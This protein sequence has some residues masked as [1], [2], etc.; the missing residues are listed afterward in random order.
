MKPFGKLILASQQQDR[1]T[2]ID[3]SQL[4]NDIKIHKLILFRGFQAPSRDEFLQFCEKFPAM[5]TLNWSF[6]PVMEMKESDDPQNY[7]FSREKV[8]FHW[9]GAFHTVPD[10]LVFSCVN[11][12]S[13]HAGGET[14][15]TNT[16]MIF[17]ETSSDQKKIWR[18]AE[19]SY[20]TEKLA[21]YGGRIQGPLVQFHPY[22]KQNILRFAEPV[23]TRLNPV[24][25]S[26]HGVDEQNAVELEQAL[27][28]KIYDPR[29][30][31]RH[32]WQVGDLLIADNHSLIH[33]RTE[34][35]KNEPRHLRRI[36]LLRT[37]LDS[38]KS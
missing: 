8:P 3:F 7:L 13:E 21:H 33:G 32:H 2:N 25:L 20:T 11:A 18:Q 10:Y 12:P 15:F 5:K 30:C 28:E 4:E 1:I 24:S 9:D 17:N 35:E 36:Q 22:S 19:L 26:I 14:L 37:D 27:T 38:A 29:Y 34:F 31:Y 23:H 16:E 6:G